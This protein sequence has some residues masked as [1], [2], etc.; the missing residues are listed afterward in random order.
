MPPNDTKA[1]FNN[2]AVAKLLSVAPPYKAVST[3]AFSSSP[4]VYVPMPAA[5]PTVKV[6]VPAVATGTV[7]TS[8]GPPAA[9]AVAEPT[10]APPGPVIV[11][12]G[13]IPAAGV[14]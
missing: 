8:V 13:C 6:Y 9:E 4:S 14:T 11:K 5:E 1:G 12:V 2:C 10:V 3:A 7:C